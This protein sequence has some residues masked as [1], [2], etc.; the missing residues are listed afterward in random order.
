MEINLICPNCKGDIVRERDEEKIIGSSIIS[1]YCFDYCSRINRSIYGEIFSYE[2][3]YED[4]GI[5]YN[6]RSSKAGLYFDKERT[7]LFKMADREQ[8][9]NL[10]GKMRIWKGIFEIES[11]VPFSSQNDFD[12]LIKRLLKLMVFS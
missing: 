7:S 8:G 5:G 11:F 2:T 10:F 9:P 3:F 12:N 6:L 4:K 1:S